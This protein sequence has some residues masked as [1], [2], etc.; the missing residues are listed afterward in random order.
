MKFVDE[1][2]YAI[3]FDDVLLMPRPS[4]VESRYDS[5][6]SLSSCVTKNFSI[7]IP[8]ISANMD[9]ITES[10]MMI[11]MHN[12][13]ALGILHRFMDI[14]KTE[15]EIRRYYTTEKIGEKEPS[16]LAV[17]LG[18]NSGLEDRLQLFEQMQVDIVCIDVA[19]G[20]CQRVI[21]LI[22]KIK[23]KYNFDVMAGN[24][25]V[26][27]AVKDLCKAG[28]DAIKV[29]IGPG[30]MCTTRVVTGCGVPQLT[31][32]IECAEAAE[33]FDVP[34]IADGGFRTSGDIVKALAAGASCIMSGSFFAGTQETPGAV[35]TKD[36][37]GMHINSPFGYK[38]KVYR[39]M[40]SE[41]AMVGWK[42][43][44]YQVTPEG[45]STLVPYKGPV[46]KIL[47]RLE[48]GIRSG[49]AYNNAFTIAELQQNAIFRHVSP[50]SLTEN[51]PH[52]KL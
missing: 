33:E 40:A 49:M 4:R 30:S 5:R 48:G 12:H 14:D 3:T 46:S 45:E 34:I 27:S 41:D 21:D 47:E 29:G 35:L 25:A 31:A 43:K 10:A 18:L 37:E 11:A 17:S 9:T 26:P 19:H 51:R 20:H 24:V 44:D 16:I 1:D 28:A 50:N 7:D 42:G 39:G 6:M 38:Y 32:I 52:W 15:R 36:P 2:W 23:N 8:I 22:E 13:G